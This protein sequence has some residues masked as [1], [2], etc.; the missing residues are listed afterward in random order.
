MQRDLILKGT[1]SM[2]N[3]K[4]GFIKSDIGD[5]YF[6]SSSIKNKDK[7]EVG[8][9]V[10]YRLEVSKRKKDSKEG[11]DLQVIQKVN[12]ENI[13]KNNKAASAL[14]KWTGIVIKDMV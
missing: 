6:H 1:I 5:T 13:S 2:F 12:A 11:V 10:E 7:I 3:G 14:V 9:L 4:F 8:D